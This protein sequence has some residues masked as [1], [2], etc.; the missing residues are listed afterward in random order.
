MTVFADFTGASLLVNF[1]CVLHSQQRFVSPW[2]F[3]GP[4][5]RCPDV[6]RFETCVRSATPGVPVLVVWVCIRPCSSCVYAFAILRSSLCYCWYCAHT[7]I[8]G[9]RRRL[10][11]S[12]EGVAPATSGVQVQVCIVLH[13]FA[14]VHGFQCQCS[15][16]IPVVLLCARAVRRDSTDSE[17]KRSAANARLLIASSSLCAVASSATGVSVQ[18]V[19]FCCIV[20][21]W[22]FV[23]AS[24]VHDLQIHWRGSTR[25]D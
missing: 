8:V 18:A 14:F 5:R 21:S 17:W 16:C 15:C 23:Y 2:Y 19:L 11:T 6:C 12:P 20:V 10:R 13:R 7:S 22:Y 1:S 9:T 3:C 24:I 25:V 4:R